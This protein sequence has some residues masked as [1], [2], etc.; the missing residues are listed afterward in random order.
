MTQVVN[1]S[2]RAG[3]LLFLLFYTI[4]IV[5]APFYKLTQKGGT[6]LVGRFGRR[7]VEFFHFCPK[8]CRLLTGV[9]VYGPW[10]SRSS[11]FIGVALFGTKYSIFLGNFLNIINLQSINILRQSL[12]FNIKTSSIFMKMHKSQSLGHTESLSKASQEPKFDIPQFLS[13]IVMIILL[14]LNND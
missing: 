13:Q 11:Y 6:I 9:S 7:L 8:L 2:W 4:F 10:S 5:E 12:F 1:S 14:F 3:C